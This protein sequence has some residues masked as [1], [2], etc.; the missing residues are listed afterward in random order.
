MSDSD[1]SPEVQA[2]LNDYTASFSPE[3]QAAQE[4][5]H[6]AHVEDRSTSEAAMA[7]EM[8]KHLGMVVETEEDAPSTDAVEEAPAEETSEEDVDSEVSDEAKSEEE[9]TR[10]IEIDGKTLKV[11]FND[12][13]KIVKTAKAAANYQKGMRKFQKERDEAIAKIESLEPEVQKY[14]SGFDKLQ[15]LLESAVEE[16]DYSHL[17]DAIVGESTSFHDEALKYLEQTKWYESLSDSEKEAHQ[18]QKEKDKELRELRKQIEDNKKEVEKK[19]KEAEEKEANA[20]RQKAQADFENAY[21]AYRFNG[22]IKDKVQEHKMNKMLK[23]NFESEFFKLDPEYQT[24]EGM[25]KIMKQESDALRKLFNI[26]K[27]NKSKA[28]NERKKK[29]AAKEMQKAVEQNE[30]KQDITEKIRS[31]N[32]IDVVNSW[33]HGN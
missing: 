11:D 8:A 23:D 26:G 30:P 4:A 28:K 1:F 18:R 19:A 10:I 33:V 9:D 20:L 32:M 31:G 7:D 15:G 24:L 2:A 21:F 22:E 6:Q 3:A 17:F 16:D 25:H 14:K 29:V 27:S 12:R 5:E 13:D